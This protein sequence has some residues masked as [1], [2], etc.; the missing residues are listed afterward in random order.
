MSEVIRDPSA[1]DEDY[2]RVELANGIVQH[3]P[4]NVGQASRPVALML[5]AGIA[6]GE[7]R[8]GQG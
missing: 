6:A 4:G 2:W 7:K 3:A 8:D 1:R 5:R